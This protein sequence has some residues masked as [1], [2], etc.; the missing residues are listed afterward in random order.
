M[1][2]RIHVSY[3][4]TGSAG[5][6]SRAH[7]RATRTRARDRRTSSS[8]PP[9]R[10]HAV[11]TNALPPRAAPAAAPIPPPPRCEGG[12][13]QILECRAHRTSRCVRARAVPSDEGQ[14]FVTFS[15][16]SR[17]V[18]T[19]ARRDGRPL[20]LLTS[21]PPPPADIGPV[22]P[23]AGSMGCAAR[24]CAAGGAGVYA[25]RFPAVPRALGAHPLDPRRHGG[26]HL[27]RAGPRPRARPRRGPGGL[28]RPLRRGGAAAISVV[29]RRR[30][31]TDSGPF[32][33]TRRATSTW[34]REPNTNTTS[35]PSR[36]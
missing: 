13:R 14:Q 9:R 25:A 8:P 4:R 10:P 34:S 31:A 21:P 33:S 7:R 29:L 35:P 30:Q 12:R 11:V 18:A 20:G 36:G 17:Q 22:A 5:A 1:K 16:G 32:A 6:P 24:L 23:V 15:A 19:F 3:R 26:G 2:G 28:Q 27:A